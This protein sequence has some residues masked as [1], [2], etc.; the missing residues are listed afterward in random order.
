M[1]ERLQKLVTQNPATV[2]STTYCPYCTKA[3][4][5]LDA[6]SVSYKELMLDEIQGEEQ[7]DAANCIYG[8]GRRFVPFIYLN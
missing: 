1:A 6:A 4:R 5:V 2:I 8:K 3:K 7:M